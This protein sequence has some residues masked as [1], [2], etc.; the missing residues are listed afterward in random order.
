VWRKSWK[1]SPSTPAARVAGIQ[2]R[3]VKLLRRIGPLRGHGPA[4]S[5]AGRLRTAAPGRWSRSWPRSWGRACDGRPPRRSR[6][7]RTQQLA[8]HG[9]I[10]QTTRRSGT[11]TLR[12]RRMGIPP[13]H[14]NGS[15]TGQVRAQAPTMAGSS[16]MP[17][18]LATSA[19]SGLPGCRCQPPRPARRR[20]AQ[21]T[22]GGCGPCGP[23]RRSLA[24]RI[25]HQP[26]RR[27]AADR[28]G[29]DTGSR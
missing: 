5:A 29:H 23:D 4:S 8:D 6:P 22:A 13:I 27:D 18:W 25:R 16:W 14:A 21:G 26:G 2:T 28:P 17:S 3:R 9:H 24:S 12:A 20:P 15:Q 19:R 10:R 11:P 7:P 1:R